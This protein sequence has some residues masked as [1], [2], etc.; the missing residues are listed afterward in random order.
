VERV[1][2]N[3]G[4]AAAPPIALE[5]PAMRGQAKTSRLQKFI[6]VT[7]VRLIQDPNKKIQARFL[8]INHS[9]AE[10]GDLAA[11]VTIWGRTSRSDEESIGTFGLKA[12]S[13]GPYEAKELSAPFNTKL[14]VYE[15][16]DWQNVTADVQIISPQ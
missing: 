4:P 12:P 9:G 15:M 14:K 11:N 6:E 3:G 7:G 10:I 13:L 8:L 5:N 1:R 2:G 16:P